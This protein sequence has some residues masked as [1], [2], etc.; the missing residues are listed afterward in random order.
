M[1]NTQLFILVPILML[2]VFALIINYMGK[3]YPDKKLF[4]A[5]TKPI[6]NDAQVIRNKLKYFI[7]CIVFLAVWLVSLY[8]LG[9]KDGTFLTGVLATG[10]LASVVWDKYFRRSVNFKAFDEDE[11]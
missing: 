2:M 5:M 7:L 10:Y 9:L 3:N 4:M 11:K 8:V 1:T 6:I